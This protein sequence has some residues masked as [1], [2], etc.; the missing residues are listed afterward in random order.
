MLNMGRGGGGDTWPLRIPVRCTSGSLGVC[1]GMLLGFTAVQAHSPGTLL[2]KGEGRT[3]K[4]TLRASSR[5]TE[6]KDISS[7]DTDN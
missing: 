7:P 2:G 3:G 6:W 5:G 1:G 4:G